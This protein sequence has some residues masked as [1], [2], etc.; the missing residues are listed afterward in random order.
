MRKNHG[1]IWK[2]NRG[3]EIMEKEPLTRNH[4]E[5]TMEEAAGGILEAGEVWKRNHVGGIWETSEK[6]LQACIRNHGRGIMEGT[7][8]RRN[9]G[10]GIVEKESWKRNPG[11]GILG[12]ESWERNH[13]GGIME[14]S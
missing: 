11:G 7:S 4:G 1:G 5:E 8:W 3:Q 10:G 13:G 2:R 14:E 6:H 12:E 9:H